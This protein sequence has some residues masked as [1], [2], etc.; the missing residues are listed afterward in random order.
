MFELEKVLAEKRNRDGKEG[1]PQFGR[2]VGTRQKVGEKRPRSRLDHAQNCARG[3]KF[4]LEPWL[5][6]DQGRRDNQ[7]DHLEELVEEAAEGEVLAL[8]VSF[9]V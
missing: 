3:E 9:V 8:Q 5:W 7:L 1:A 2:K 4:E 6:V